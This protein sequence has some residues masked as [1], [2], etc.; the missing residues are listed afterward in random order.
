MPLPYLHGA[1]IDHIVLFVS[2]D[3]A[4][5]HDPKLIIDLDHQ[6]VFVPIMGDGRFEAC[7]TR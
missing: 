7:M 3:K 1:D 2:A 4:D 5:I 6:A